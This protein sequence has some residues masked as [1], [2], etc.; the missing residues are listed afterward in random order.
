M[1]LEIAITAATSAPAP[2]LPSHLLPGAGS[3]R[4][5]FRV[6]TGEVPDRQT[7]TELLGEAI[8]DAYLTDYNEETGEGHF[9]VVDGDAPEVGAVIDL[10]GENVESLELRDLDHI[11]TEDHI[12][13]E[14]DVYPSMNIEKYYHNL[15][16]HDWYFTF[17]DDPSVYKQGNKDNER[18][19]GIARQ[20]GQ[21]YL[22]LLE[23]FSKHHF[24]GEPWG[25][26]RWDKPARPVNGVLVLPSAPETAEEEQSRT[27]VGVAESEFL[28]SFTFAPSP[29]DAHTPDGSHAVKFV[30]EPMDPG[31]S[32]KASLVVAG[33]EIPNPHAIMFATHS[34]IA[35]VPAAV[36]V[37]LHKPLSAVIVA[38]VGMGFFH[39]RNLVVRFENAR[40]LHVQT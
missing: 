16:R 8:V 4:A 34:A 22:A 13:A 38:A 15:D 30:D 37:T 33:Y 21:D 23:A 11:A 5:T 25:T 24:S 19:H 29:E 32:H 39:L 17:S 9:V 27:P 18:I 7:M 6:V 28:N 10:S 1:K 2:D 26:A 35:V 36:L 20:H 3:D 31:L 12:D 14:V 40:G